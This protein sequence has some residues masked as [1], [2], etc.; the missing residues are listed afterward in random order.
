MPRDSSGTFTHSPATPFVTNTPI[1]SSVANARASDV[2][3]A[4]TDSLSRSGSGGMLAPLTFTGIAATIRSGIANGASAVAHI[5]DSVA[6]LTTA[7]A[8]LLSLRNAGVEKAHFDKDGNLFAA[9]LQ[10]QS[11]NIN[12]AAGVSVQINSQLADG[13]TAVGT[14]IDTTAAYAN[15]AAKLASIRNAGAEK[16]YFDKDG[17]LFV[18]GVQVAPAPVLTDTPVAGTGWTITYHSVKKNADGLVT[19]YLNLASGA[20]PGAFQGAQ[21]SDG[22]R[23]PANTLIIWWNNTSSAVAGGTLNATGWV[24]PPNTPNSAFVIHISFYAA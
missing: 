4:L 20:S 13:A 22:F 23:P 16:A 21:L 10:S 14:I 1:A 24:A 2:A 11:G 8:K 5:L 12:G 18:A 17:K 6:S 3:T 19:C 15:A 9:G 7:G